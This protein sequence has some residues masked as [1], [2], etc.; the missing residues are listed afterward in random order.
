MTSCTL[1]WQD[2]DDGLLRLRMIICTGPV[3]PNLASVREGEH[4]PAVLDVVDQQAADHGGDQGLKSGLP[5]PERRPVLLFHGGQRLE[6]SGNVRSTSTMSGRDLLVQPRVTSAVKEG[7]V[8]HSGS[9]ID[10]D[11]GEHY[12]AGHHHRILLVEVL[13]VPQD[14]EMDVHF[15]WISPR[16]A[17]LKVTKRELE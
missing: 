7:K 4:L 10:V 17:P 9:V 16:L 2:E 15:M 1:T 6:D 12:Q 14:H 13:T 3:Q 8:N 11:E 5:A